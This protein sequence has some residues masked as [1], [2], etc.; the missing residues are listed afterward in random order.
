[1][2]GRASN[3]GHVVDSRIRDIWRGP[4]WD[5][6]LACLAIMLNVY[7]GDLKKDKQ[8]VRIVKSSGYPVGQG[9]TVTMYSVVLYAHCVL[10]LSYNVPWSCFLPSVS[11]LVSDS[12]TAGAL[13]M[14]SP[15]SLLNTLPLINLSSL[16]CLWFSRLWMVYPVARTSMVVVVFLGSLH[17]LLNLAT[18][19]VRSQLCSISSIYVPSMR[20]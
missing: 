4:A 12:H 10:F 15:C 8:M 16:L 1:M 14:I 5:Q 17:I 7:N 9:L 11:S 2:L 18:W 19:H 3:C 20:K 13:P 6:F